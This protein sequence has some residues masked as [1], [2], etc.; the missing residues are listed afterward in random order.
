MSARAPLDLDVLVVGGGP[1]GAACAIRLAQVGARVAIVEA[2]DFS[3][4]RVGETL[5]P[6]LG[7]LLLRLGVK[8]DAQQWSAPCSGVAAAWGQPNAPQRPS[9]LNPYGR[10]WRVDRKTFDRTL[11]E[12]ARSAGAVA[13]LGCRFVSAERHNGAWTFWLE[14]ATRR[15]TGRARWIVAA[16]GRA[17]RT[18]LAPGR[19]RQ[20]IDRLIGLA[21]RDDGAEHARTADAALVEA[22]PHG[23]WYSVCVPD[24]GRVAMFF[25]DSDLLPRGKR[26]RAA[27]LLDALDRAPLTR[28]AC[29]FAAI[30][31]AQRRWSGF[32]ARSSLQR[33]A[34]SDG[35]IAV[36][37][38]LMAFDP[39]C[40]RGIGEAIGSAVAAGDWLL[41]A[42]TGDG[43]AEPVPSWVIDAADRFNRYRGERLAIYGQETRWPAAPFWQR[44]CG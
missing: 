20:W 43:D 14:I 33:F 41:T 19:R 28:S 8:I 1:A 15:S 40:G 22:T 44:R 18:P 10:G 21:V 39:L 2:S 36:G 32:D 29:A 6:S 34:L 31:I 7:P 30:A 37:D 42:G 5:D 17:A 24:G 38:A 11:F 12:Q 16:T 26:D 25:T 13:S 27:F 35:W 9:M 23:W 3:H 4:F